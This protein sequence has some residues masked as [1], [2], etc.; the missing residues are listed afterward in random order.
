M[1]DSYFKTLQEMSKRHG[2]GCILVLPDKF[3]EFLLKYR[4]KRLLDIG[5]HRMLLKGFVKK[6]LNDCEYIGLDVYHYSAKIHVQASG[7]YLPFRD[8][9]VDCVSLIETLEHIPDY[10][11]ALKEIHRII[12][13]AVFIQS[14]GCWDKCALID[15]SH[16][17]VLHP[18]NL[19]KL[20]KFLGYSKV[21]YGIVKG[22]FWL[23]GEK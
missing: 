23:V 20:M 4:P 7:D 9:S 22:T 14:V 12:R 21:Y 1:S 10:T 6:I 15:E 11:K 5:C 13:K 8:S 19:A 2:W 17:H 16:F 3:K 18:H